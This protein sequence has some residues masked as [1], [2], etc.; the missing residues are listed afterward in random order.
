MD[1]TLEYLAKKYGKKKVNLQKQAKEPEKEEEKESKSE[2][3][4]QVKESTVY[5]P[6]EMASGHS[7]ISVR[8]NFT[9]GT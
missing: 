9:I 4:S 6:L 1:K 8:M 3:E 7:V 2:I 5:Q